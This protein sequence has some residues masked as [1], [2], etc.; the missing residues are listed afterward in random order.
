MKNKT[1]AISD[2]DHLYMA[3]EQAIC[4]RYGL[5]YVL[6]QCKTENDLIEHLPGYSAVINQYAPFTERVFAAL[7]FA[8][9]AYMLFKAWQTWTV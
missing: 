2:C 7:L 5:D 4:D 6:F 8:L 1:I 3:E 9:A